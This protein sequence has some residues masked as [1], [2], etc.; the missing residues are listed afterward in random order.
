MTLAGSFCRLTAREALWAATRGGARALQLEDQIG[1]LEIGCL[2]DF[3]IWN[4]ADERL[5]PYYYGMNLIRQVYKRGQ[6]V[7][8]ETTQTEN[9]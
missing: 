9:A 3:V 4:G 5:I 1:S 6:R 7:A 8:F 2:A